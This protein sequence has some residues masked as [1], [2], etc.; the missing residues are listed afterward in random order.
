MT[1]YFF[2]QTIDVDNIVVSLA[3]SLS[4]PLNPIRE[5]LDPKTPIGIVRKRVGCVSGIEPNEHRRIALRRLGR[6]VWLSK[7]GGL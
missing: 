3:N 6:R 7:V 2:T 4:P 1:Y 5:F